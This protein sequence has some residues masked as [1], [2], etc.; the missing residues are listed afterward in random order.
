MR[1]VGIDEMEGG[2]NEIKCFRMKGNTKIPV[3]LDPN[4]NYVVM[5][6]TKN[7]FGS[8]NLS[9][10]FK[11]DLSRNVVEEIGYCICVDNMI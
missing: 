11:N 5:T 6:L 10:V 8:T 9:V 2:K 1:S 7:R 3:K 4:Q